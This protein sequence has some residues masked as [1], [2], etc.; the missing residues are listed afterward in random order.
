[1]KTLRRFMDKDSIDYEEAGEVAVDKRKL[2]LN[3]R[4]D[5]PQVPEEE[6]EEEEE[7]DTSQVDDAS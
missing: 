5:R 3:R 7:E 4:F 2:L 6:E 1:M